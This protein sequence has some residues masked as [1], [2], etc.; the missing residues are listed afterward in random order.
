[1]GSIERRAFLIAAAAV[2]F[3]LTIAR[4]AG[5]TDG[6]A[7]LRSFID[8]LNAKD[9]GKLG[10]FIQSHFSADT[11]VAQRLE[12]LKSL[13]AHTPFTFSKILEQHS[14][15]IVALVLDGDG[16]KTT[17]TVAYND[18][19]IA[20]VGIRAGTGGDPQPPAWR[21]LPSLVRALRVEDG[22]PAMVAAMI[23]RT[24]KS[25]Y[26][27]G[28]RTAGSADAAGVND[29]WKIG[30]IGKPLCSSVIGRL[31]ERG[32]LDW[33][34]RLANFF[35]ESSMRPEYRD[36]TLVDLMQ[37]RGGIAPA[38]D[39]QAIDVDRIVAGA[40]RAPH[41]R[42]NFARDLLTRMPVGPR[43]A[44]A[45]SN[46]G[47][48]ILGSIAETVTGTPY[49]QLLHQHI[50]QPLAL[51]R[52]YTAADAL[53]PHPLGHRR[54][55]GRLEPVQIQGPLEKML[56]PAGG[57]IWMSMQDLAQFGW[58]HLRGLNGYN[59]FLKSATIRR[60]HSGLPEPDGRQSYACGWG[61]SQHPRAGTMHGHNGGDGTFLAEFGVFPGSGLVVASAVNAGGDNGAPYR[62]ILAVGERY[63]KPLP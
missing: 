63:F 49:E 2:P 30:S 17:W 60:L 33:T 1:M 23:L 32:K 25:A 8:V 20:S 15:G 46:G 57:G 18:D 40:T 51:A 43:G 37:H 34:S 50:F 52:G 26:A 12:R 38:T 42:A 53:P 48:A 44:F 14:S 54:N 31:I 58:A 59:G 19:K 47:Y 45:Y 4:A 21:D 28:V 24:A 7:D 41:I 39:F 55:G 5:A 11:P 6:E 56:A 62:A 16:V 10:D 22:A 29:P 35:P 13:W 9:E 27:D 36:V 61:V 3:A